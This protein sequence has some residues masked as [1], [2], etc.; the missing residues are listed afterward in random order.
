[1]IIANGAAVART[2]HASAQAVT[3]ARSGT[4]FRG[5]IG[6]RPITVVLSGFVQRLDGYACARLGGEIEEQAKALGL[7]GPS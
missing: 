3:M 2:L 7:M 5:E 1:M 4:A 6:N